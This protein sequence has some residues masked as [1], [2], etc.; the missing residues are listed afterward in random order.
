MGKRFVVRQ[1]TIA[2]AAIVRAAFAAPSKGVAADKPHY[3]TIATDDGNY[4]V[5][6]LT[7]VRQGDPSAEV[8]AQRKER[9]R[10]LQQEVGAG[11][12]A[13]YV[14]EAERNAEVVRNEK[15]FE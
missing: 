7:G 14:S 10:R 12:F 15:V 5:F 8:E 4:A 6:E 13:A 1:D 11:E 3:G 9:A 2:P